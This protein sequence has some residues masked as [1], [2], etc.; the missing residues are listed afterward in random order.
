MSKITRIITV[1]KSPADVYA[2]VSTPENLAKWFCNKAEATDKGFKVIWTTPDGNTFGFDAEILEAQP[3]SRFVYR[4]IEDTPLT[5]TFSI[6]AH[7]EGTQLTLTESGFPDGEKGE[8]MMK[9]HEQGWEYFLQ[10]MQQ[11][12]D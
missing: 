4:T 7:A 10:Q 2:L 1:K 11:I 3:P 5:S 6:E 12:V 9:E 8:N